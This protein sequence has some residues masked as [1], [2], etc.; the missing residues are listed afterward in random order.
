MLPAIVTSTV[1]EAAT[2]MAVAAGEVSQK[3]RPDK[4]DPP[5][6]DAHPAAAKQSMAGADL[7]RQTADPLDDDSDVEMIDKEN[8]AGYGS[9]QAAYS[10]CKNSSPLLFIF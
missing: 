8:P 4:P 2:G 5:A 3:Q 10:Q 1:P 7:L 9:A 6:T